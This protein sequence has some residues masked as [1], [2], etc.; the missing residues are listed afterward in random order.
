MPRTGNL[1]QTYAWITFNQF[2]GRRKK[3]K[4]KNCCYAQVLQFKSDF[5]KCV[6]HYLEMALSNN[7]N[8]VINLEITCY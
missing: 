8:E 4:H 6:G 5:L 1:R 7:G 3:R 2:L